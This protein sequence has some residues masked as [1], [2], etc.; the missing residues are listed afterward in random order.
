VETSQG[1]QGP[2]SGSPAP[3]SGVAD[4]VIIYAQPPSDAPTSGPWANGAEPTGPTPYG[5]Q[6][7]AAP[8]LTAAEPSWK[9]SGEHIIYSESNPN[10]YLDDN[11]DGGDVVEAAVLPWGPGGNRWLAWHDPHAGAGER[12]GA[13]DALA[14]VPVGKLL[15]AAGKGVAAVAPKLPAVGSRGARAT[16]LRTNAH[17]IRLNRSCAK[18]AGGAGGGPGRGAG[19]GPRRGARAQ[20]RDAEPL[21]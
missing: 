15:G 4:E 18:L 5:V 17:A 20:V 13:L 10:G 7:Q 19:C 3:P 6:P 21:R 1:E 16:T 12:A 2:P 11:D 14:V 8:T 9:T